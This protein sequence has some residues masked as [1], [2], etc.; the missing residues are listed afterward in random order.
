MNS[1]K[2]TKLSCICNPIDAN[3][4]RHTVMYADLHGGVDGREARRE[5]VEAN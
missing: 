4:R 2:E 1:E 3:I 5:P